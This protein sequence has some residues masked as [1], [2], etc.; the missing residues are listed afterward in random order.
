[1]YTVKYKL[2]GQSFFRTLKNVKGDGVI[3]DSGSRFFILMNE[4]RIEISSD[5]E[6]IFSPDRFIFIKKEMESTVGQPI[7]TAG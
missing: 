2:R 6:I 1:M 7:I 4:T 3:P 5:S